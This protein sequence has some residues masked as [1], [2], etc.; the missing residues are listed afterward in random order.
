MEETYDER[1]AIDAHRRETRLANN[2]MAAG[3]LS[4]EKQTLVVRKSN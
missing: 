1:R 2:A 3:A 4:T